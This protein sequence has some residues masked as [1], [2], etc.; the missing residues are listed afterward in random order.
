MRNALF[1]PLALAT[2]ALPLVGLGAAAGEPGAEHSQRSDGRYLYVW[3]GHVDHEIADFLAVIDFDEDS[4]GYGRIISTVP[5]PA[6]GATFNE[7]HHMH[8]SADGNILGCGGLLSV[9]SGQPGIF[10][11][12]M[13]NPRK[14]R[15]LFST[16]DKL[17][18][19]TDD[20]FPLP[21]GG[22]LITQM[23]SANGDAPGRVVEFDRQLR[24]VGRWPTSPPAGGFNPH[25]ITVRPELNLMMTSDFILPASTLNV[26]A[27]PPVLRN[28]VRVWDFNKR[29]ILR[30]I[31]AP[32]AVGTMDVKLIPGD[33][34]GRAYTAGMFNG[35]IY[36]V[37]P[38]AG[39]ATPA[40][41]TG[42]Q[43]GMPQILQVTRN[44]SRLL[45]G[46]F[47]S[48]RIIMLDT[49]DRSRLSQ[50]A[51]LDLGDGAGPHNIML[52]DNDT[53]LVV[54]DYFLDEDDFPFANPGKVRLGGDNKVHVV[55]VTPNSL[56]RDA[57]FNLDFDTVFR[58]GPARPH[59]IA[60]R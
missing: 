59:G 9:L 26:V 8:L 42:P 12:E 41:D 28:T 21:Q 51:A 2:V 40:F 47:Q 13:S 4:P 14:P 45:T 17:S 30:T 39:S 44:G 56:G 60:V 29:K 6:R 55:K 33:F 35:L 1:L 16:S 3:A 10:F 24:Q 23:G 34:R 58:T 53:R 37:D 31:V 32:E 36:L 20:F 27:G 50:V 46:L 7:P 25:G 22:F 38:I 43:G 19:I 54:T 57:R 18:S 49:T 5:L 52:T 11:F 15:F 48:G